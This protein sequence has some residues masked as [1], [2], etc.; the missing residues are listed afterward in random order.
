MYHPRFSTCLEHA[1]HFI[2]SGANT[3]YIKHVWVS[4]YNINT[5]Y[6]SYRLPEI[7]YKMARLSHAAIITSTGNESVQKS[8]L[9]AHTCNNLVVGVYSYANKYLN[10]RCN[11]QNINF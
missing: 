5:L 11:P 7:P 2:A 9:S 10:I 6:F 8:D 3:V 1:R 4:S